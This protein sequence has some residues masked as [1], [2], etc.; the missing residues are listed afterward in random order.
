MK[1]N[2][3]KDKAEEGLARMMMVETRAYRV[4][5]GQILVSM[6]PSV[7][8][9]KGAEKAISSVLPHSPIVGFS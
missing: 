9:L 8:W 7:L 4:T 1:I 6:G 5:L 3:R 2:V